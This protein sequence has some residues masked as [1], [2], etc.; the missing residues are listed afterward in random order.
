VREKDPDKISQKRF[1]VACLSLSRLLLDFFNGVICV[2]H[3]ARV[4]KG[5]V[6]ILHSSRIVCARVGNPRGVD[7]LSRSPI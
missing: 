3:S 1:V 7:G 6:V 5:A 2:N 4:G